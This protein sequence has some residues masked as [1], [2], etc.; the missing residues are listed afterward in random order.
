MKIKEHNDKLVVDTEYG[1]LTLAQLLE[2]AIIDSGKKYSTI[3]TEL[4][5]VH[6][7]LANM[8]YGKTIGL[9]AQIQALMHLGYEI[10]ITRLEQ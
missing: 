3:Q 2:V 1:E 9:N 6:P 4:G 10:E 8:K 5:W 7:R